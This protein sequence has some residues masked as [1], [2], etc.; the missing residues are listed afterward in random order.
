VGT[1]Q[2]RYGGAKV[3]VD[4]GKPATTLAAALQLLLSL[5]GGALTQHFGL[6]EQ[7]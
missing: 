1:L 4:L 3:R 6:L 7:I 5:V 2:Q